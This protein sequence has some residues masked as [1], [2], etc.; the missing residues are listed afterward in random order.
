MLQVYDRVLSSQSVP[1]LALTLLVL[2]LYGRRR[3]RMARA[4]C[5]ASSLTFR[6]ILA[7]HAAAAR[8]RSPCR[9]RQG[10]RPPCAICALRRHRQLCVYAIF[11]APFSPLFLPSFML[12]PLFGW[13]ALFGA[14]VLV[15]RPYQRTQ[16]ARLNREREFERSARCVDTYA[17]VLKALGMSTAIR[18]RWQ[19]ADAADSACPFRPH[20]FAT[21]VTKAFCLLPAIGHLRPALARDQGRCSPGAMIA[22][23][24]GP[25]HRASEQITAVA[26]MSARENWA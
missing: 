17:E 13:W 4:T 15:A 20:P 22:H 12:H 2:V 26:Q 6:A 8:W 25:R 10:H 1:T 18:R 5:S 7:N 9:S 19:A 11:D 3:P 21:S 14:V 24:D 23:P 16:L